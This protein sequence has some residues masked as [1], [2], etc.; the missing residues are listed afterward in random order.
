M[1]NARFRVVGL[2]FV[3]LVGVMLAGCG[4]KYAT[5]RTPAGEDLMLLGHD[6]V[7][8]F[9]VGKPVRG[10]PSILA[11]YKD[12]TYYF[13]SEANRTQFLADPAKYEPQYGA[14][15]ADGA[16]YGVKLG[17]DPTEFVIRNGRL[18]IFGDVV[19]REFFL[20]RPDW[21]IEKGDLMWPETGSRGHITQ[22]LYRLTF[23]VPWYRTGR[24]LYAEWH[25]KNPG[26]TLN[27]DPGGVF[28]NLFV[29]YP[30][31][32][33]REGHQQPALGIPGI[34]PCPPA[35]SGQVSVGYTPK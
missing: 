11:K 28:N 35:C 4:V 23:R 9:T 27:Y 15:C 5:V 14:F 13:A 18:F 29:K 20:L 34:D 32:R 25:A 19:G 21:D 7:A 12:V 26:K 2:A 24:E 33:A 16:A 3:T 8:Y 30:G 17:S 31:W 10:Y 1:R 22:S 6:P